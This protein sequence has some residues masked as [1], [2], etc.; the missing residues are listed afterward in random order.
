MYRIAVTGHRPNKLYGY[1]L[2][3]PKWIKLAWKMREILLDRIKTHKEIECITGMALGVDQ[4]FGLVALKLKNQNYPVSI[5]AA[6]PCLNQPEKWPDRTYWDKIK[7]NSDIVHYV[8]NGPYTNTCMNDRNKYMV[9]RAD[10]IIAVWDGSGGGTSRCV[11]YAKKQG[12]P[13]INIYEPDD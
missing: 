11:N 6:V 7:D 9:D 13:V 2:H 1:D 3:H 10:E 4:L 8:H 12:K 5:L